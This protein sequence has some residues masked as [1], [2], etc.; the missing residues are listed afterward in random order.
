MNL[1]QKL[2]HTRASWILASALMLTIGLSAV[3]SKGKPSTPTFGE[4]EIVFIKNSSTLALLDRDGNMQELLSVRGSISAPS[5]AP[6]GDRIAFLS[7]MD[8]TWGLYVIDVDGQNLTR[9]SDTQQGGSYPAWSPDG[10]WIAYTDPNPT[11]DTN[12]RDI[13]VIDMDCAEPGLSGCAFYFDTPGFREWEP[14]WSPSGDRLVARADLD[15]SSPMTTEVVVYPFT[16]SPSPA[17][18][19][20]QVLT[21][22]TLPVLSKVEGEGNLQF[23][24]WSKETDSWLAVLSKDAASNGDLFIIN[25]VTLKAFNLTGCPECDNLEQPSWSPCNSR[26]VVVTRDP[27]NRPDQTYRTLA[28]LNIEYDPSTGQ[29]V[30]QSITYLP[31]QGRRDWYTY[32]DWKPGVCQ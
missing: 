23:P 18:G 27:D 31:R 30:L 13:F 21:A 3:W 10:R 17:L 7:N 11:R 29:P 4:P 12:D 14:A 26:M 8:H 24:A 28:F 22:Q 25:T 32:P 20:R 15:G 16:D 9:L 1:Y 19:P 6:G 2:S 5:W